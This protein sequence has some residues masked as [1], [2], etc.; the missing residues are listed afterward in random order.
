L[1]EFTAAISGKHEHQRELRAL[2]QKEAGERESQGRSRLAEQKWIETDHP[3]RPSGTPDGGQWAAKDGGGGSGNSEASASAGPP[4]GFAS[5]SGPRRIVAQQVSTRSVGH[6]WN[7]VSAVTDDSIRPF[8]SDDA[9]AYA[10]GSY[11]GATDPDHNFG[12]YGGV[13]HRDYNRVVKEELKT[14]IKDNGIKKMTKEQMRDFIGLIEN[15]LDTHGEPHPVIGPFN[16]AVKSMVPKGTS[17]PTKMD[18]IVAAGRKYMKT[19][20]FRLLAAGA[21]LSGFLSDAVAAQVQS[22]DVTSESGHF[23]RAIKAL[24]DGDLNLARQQ[25]I[26]DSNSLYTEIMDKVNPHAAYR[27]KKKMEQEFDNARNREYK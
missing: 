24:Q 15:G 5:H 4:V 3:R 23:K 1:L 14:F 21:V 25:L 18:D 17:T 9:V 10:A 11:S 12:T 8:L 19:Q 22:L 13:R 27:F 16:R 6:H 2:L 26:G 7:P 20:R